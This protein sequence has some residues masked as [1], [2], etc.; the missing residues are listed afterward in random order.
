MD[1]GQ[2]LF[3]MFMDR[4]RVET[5]KHPKIECSVFLCEIF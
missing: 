5:H 2:V 4:D 1:I 3:C